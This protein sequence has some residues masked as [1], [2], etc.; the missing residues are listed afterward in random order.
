MSK[1]TVTGDFGGRPL[2]I[3]CGKLA[4]QASGAV[5]VQYGDTIV[6]VTAGLGKEPRE[7]FDFLPLTVVYQETTFAAGKI[8]GGFFKR[9]GR[10]SEFETLTSRFIDRPIRRSFL[11]T[12]ATKYRSLPP[13]YRRT[14]RMRPI[15]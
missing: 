14:K 9:E 7:G 6:L 12:F 2:T 10:P 15:S 1:Q 11:R 8:P 13:C 3:E 4:K 5:T